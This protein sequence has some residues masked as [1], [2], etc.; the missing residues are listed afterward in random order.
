MALERRG[1]SRFP[2]DL[3]VF[4]INNQ[5]LS[6][7]VKNFSRSGMRVILDT[8]DINEKSEVEI[9]IQRPDYNEAIFTTSSVAWKKCFEGKCEV[10]L[11]F[12]NFP[13]QA[14]AAFLEYG[15]KKWLKEKSHH[16]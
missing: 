15:Y 1:A 13:A 5:Q 16:S 6:G 4:K 2:V 11:K 14:K 3:Y 9:G 10:G 7:N 8:P 12:N